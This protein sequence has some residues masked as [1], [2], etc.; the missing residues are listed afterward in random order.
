MVLVLYIATL[1]V[2]YVPFARYE[3]QLVQQQRQQDEA[4]RRQEES[5]AKQEAM[6]K[7]TIEHEMKLRNENDIK[8]VRAEVEAQ[9]RMARENH[10]INMEQL[11]LK[12][13]ENRETI[14]QSIKTAGSVLG[15][16]ANA[17]VS[18]WDKVCLLSY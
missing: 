14:L 17:F 3:D 4:L 6:R 5:T 1:S 16:G 15:A 8:K 2:Q 7:A 10:D 11:R 9:A 13:Q 18:D 12:A